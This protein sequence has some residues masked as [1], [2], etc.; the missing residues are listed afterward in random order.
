M[1][2]TTATAPATGMGTTT[3]TA[4]ATM[5][6]TVKSIVKGDLVFITGVRS[7][8]QLSA[9][10][11]ILLKAAVTATPAPGASTGQTMTVSPSTPASNGAHL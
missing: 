11:L 4:P 1:G 7:H 2:T 6:I 3:P 5:P 10:L 8:G 9:Q